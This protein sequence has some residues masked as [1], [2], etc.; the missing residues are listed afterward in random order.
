ME[1]YDQ[2]KEMNIMTRRISAIC[3]IVALVLMF[4]GTGAATLVTYTVYDAPGGTPT[5]QT[6]TADFTFPS[7]TQLQIVLTETT[8]IAAYTLTGAPAILTGIGFHLPGVVAL[9]G[10]SNGSVEIALNSRSWGFDTDAI[11][12]GTPFSDNTF[13]VSREWGAVN[14]T[15]MDGTGIFDF[16]SGNSAHINDADGT[17]FFGTNRDGPDS[18][19]GPQ[20]GLLRDSTAR[21]GQGVVSD[22]VIIVL[23]LSAS[24]DS[25][26]QTTFLNSLPSHSPDYSYTGSIVEYGS[27]DGWGYPENGNGAIPEPGTLILLGSGLAGLAG[28]GKLKLRRK[29]R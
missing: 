21:G 18:I 27:S 16:V 20:A 22:S 15:A 9:Q 8:P 7:A 1:I 19:D 5:G 10:G 28:Y 14:N 23:T 26:A 11:N 25:T 17:Q 12:P 2:Q 6:A 29:K 24:M 3:F 13:Y 4:A